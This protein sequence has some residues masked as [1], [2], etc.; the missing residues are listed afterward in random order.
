MKISESAIAICMA[1]YNGEAYIAEQIES[2][3]KQ[4]YEEWVLFVRDDHSKDSTQQIVRNYAEKYPEKIILIDDPS[5]TGGSSKKNFAAIVG[6]VKERYPFNYYMF[7]DQDDFWLPYK[8]EKTFDCLKETE[9]RTRGP[10]L[11]HT[12]LR[13]V[14]SKLNELGDSFFSYRALNPDVRDLNHLLIQNNI[15]GCTMMWNKA[16]NDIVTLSDE[17]VA[18]HDWWLALSACCFG[19]IECLKEPTILYRQHENN[20]VGATK[21]NTPAFIIG[22]LLKSNHVKDTLKMS[23]TQAGAFLD[24]YGDRLDP[25]QR[26]IIERYSKLYSHHKPARIATIVK[27]GHFKQGLVQI[28]GELMFI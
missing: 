1:T 11:V 15:T 2:I 3:L 12:D 13:V 25:E 28:I 7:S 22:R 10:V 18:M 6:W 20:V 24:Y 21:V 16:L 17:R 9:D 14:D 8:I 19:T 27:G 5:L 23:V 4:T 26:G